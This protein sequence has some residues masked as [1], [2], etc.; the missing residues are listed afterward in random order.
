MRVISMNRKQLSVCSCADTRRTQLKKILNILNSYISNSTKEVI[1]VKLI[2]HL[3]NNDCGTDEIH[4]NPII[5]LKFFSLASTS[6]L[7]IHSTKLHANDC[8]RFDP[9]V[10]PTE[11][12]DHGV[13]RKSALSAPDNPPRITEFSGKPR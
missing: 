7:E 9:S 8:F 1:R 12:V 2:R 5:R 13:Q 6:R 4:A 3:W 10:A 11:F